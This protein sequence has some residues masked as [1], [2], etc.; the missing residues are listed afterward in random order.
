MATHPLITPPTPHAHSTS[1][2]V[3]PLS[4]MYSA[5]LE[6]CFSVELERGVWLVSQMRFGEN[7]SE[8]L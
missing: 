8:R 2:T 7:T 6:N 4:I 3:Q 5:M 1:N